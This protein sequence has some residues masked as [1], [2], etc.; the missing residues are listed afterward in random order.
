[1]MIIFGNTKELDFMFYSIIK[2]L[3][4][5]IYSVFKTNCLNYK[6]KDATTLGI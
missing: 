2:L 5:K 1:M 3:K 4:I 6:L